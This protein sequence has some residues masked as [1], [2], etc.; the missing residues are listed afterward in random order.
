MQ[1]KRHDSLG[2]RG[3]GGAAM[4]DTDAEV[5]PLVQEALV[6][7]P[8]AVKQ[9]LK[10]LRSGH[11]DTALAP[12]L[13]VFPSVVAV[14]PLF[15]P[16]VSSY[17]HLS[18]Q[19]PCRPEHAPLQQR[20]ASALLIRTLQAAAVLNMRLDRKQLYPKQLHIFECDILLLSPGWEVDNVDHRRH[21]IYPQVPHSHK[22]A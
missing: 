7:S 21:T 19:Q 1:R 17:I 5:V 14:D 8:T 10:L 20:C 6:R 4:C 9:H 2:K 22:N 11:R 16:K 12:R 3:H 15:L 13:A 18:H